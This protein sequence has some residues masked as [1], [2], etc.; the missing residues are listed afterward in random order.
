MVHVCS[1]GRSLH[2]G[3]Q[4]PISGVQSQEK[5]KRIE[6][7]GSNIKQYSFP[8]I[9]INENENTNEAGCSEIIE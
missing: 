8:D 4:Y 5:E 2:W 3:A 7:T 1:G 9:R 6:Y